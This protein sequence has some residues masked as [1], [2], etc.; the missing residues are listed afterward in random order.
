M[1]HLLVFMHPSN[2]SF[3]GSLLRAYQDELVKNG[4]RVVVRSLYE[5]NF[6]PILTVEEYKDTFKGIYKEDIQQ[7]HDYLN[8]ADAVTFLFPFWWGGFP[9]IGKGY[10]DRVLSFGFA[11]RLNGETPIP[12]LNGKKAAF[13]CTTG[14]PSEEYEKSGMHERVVRLTDD[15][16]FRFCGLELVSHTFF[17]G[18]LVCSDEERKK[19]MA[20]TK[21][22]AASWATAE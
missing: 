6:N 18:V 16:I 14:S 20:Q 13:I 2:D 11:Y 9:S 15:A 4:H 7:E 21:E 8:W 10:I 17:G 3:N 19:M 5:M 22:I 1:N 12:L